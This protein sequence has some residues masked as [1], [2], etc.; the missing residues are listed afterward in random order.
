[1]SQTVNLHTKYHADLVKAYNYSS[2][3]A[4]KTS[5]EFSW[6]GVNTIV[7]TSL[8]TD[9]L[10]NYNRTAAGN[11]Y[12]TPTEV[13]DAQQTLTLRMDRSYTKTVDKG[14][15]QESNFLRTGAAVTKAYM[16]ERV[17]PEFE[18]H[19]LSEAAKNAGKTVVASGA[20][21][22]SNII[23][24]LV[25]IEVAFDDARVPKENRYVAL[26][27]SS[28]ALIRQSL[29]NLDNVT[30]RML[31]KG[32]V[33][34]FGTLNIMGY[35]P[36]DMPAGA[37]AVAW[38]RDS[39]VAPRT[40]YD[41]KVHNDPPQVS[42]LLV[43]GRY[44]YDAFVVGARCDG[45]VVLAL[46]ANKCTAPTITKGTTTTTIAAGTGETIYYTVD[47]SDPR[48]SNSAQTYSAAITNPAAGDVI[49]A[50]AKANGKFVS[51]LAALK[52]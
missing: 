30:D 9:P 31:I 7:L 52:F 28:V 20:L 47:G 1:M 22:K 36:S 2:Q 11:R 45:V 21:S 12:G 38:H 39:L 16:N 50:V 33:G 35:S 13:A 3:L 5:T 32:V 37:L 19:V 43:E 51:D 41:A 27:N 24:E 15:Y 42:G 23:E 17:A 6:S 46:A 10:N 34:K 48:Y 29:T 4:G 8:L 44:R 14:N 25:N 40:I 49:R 26:H 18:Q